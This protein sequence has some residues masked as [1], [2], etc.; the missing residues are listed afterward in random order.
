VFGKRGTGIYQD[1]VLRD[2]NKKVEERTERLEAIIRARGKKEKIVGG[3]LTCIAM[4]VVG[5]VYFRAKKIVSQFERHPGH[6][7]GKNYGY[8]HESGSTDNYVI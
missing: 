5:I 6:H 3:L 1:N 7:S 8:I 2:V 4:L